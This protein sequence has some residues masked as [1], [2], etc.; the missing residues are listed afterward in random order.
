MPDHQSIHSATSLAMGIGW[1]AKRALDVGAS[2]LGLVTLL[3]ILLVLGLVIVA[4]SGWPPLFTQVRVGKGG[5]LFKLYK[6]RTM[7]VGAETQG[8]GLFFAE[9]DTRF[10]SVGTWLRRY[11]LDE[12]PQLWNVLIGDQSLVGPR[13]M[14]PLTANKLNADQ[15]RRHRVRPGIT[16][17]AQV[18][19]RNTITWSRRV[20]LDNWYIDNWSIWLDGR[21]LLRTI[22]V[23]VSSRA[24]SQDQFLPG[25]EMD[26]L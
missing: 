3:P 20:T 16:G 24:D 6:L 7:V 25:H 10:T 8:A 18:N 21:I 2:L 14:V 11:S 22:P 12:L 4:E 5:R 1:S 15:Q 13:A 19:G 9:D 26:D 23:V 17:W